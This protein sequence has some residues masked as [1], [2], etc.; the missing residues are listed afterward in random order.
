VSANRS[1]TRNVAVV[2]GA[3]RGVGKGIAEELGAA[4]AVVYVTGRSVRGEA[5]TVALPGTVDETADRVTRAG[6]TGVALHCDH[7]D[8]S[9]VEAVF[10]RVG[11][12]RGR[13]DLLVNNV[14]GGYEG[15]HEGRYEEFTK[16][17]WEQPVT[18]WDAMFSAGVRAHYVASALAA[19]MMV[20]QGRGLIVNV[21]SF[22]GAGREP[23]VALGVA[24]G[25]TDRL[26]ASTAGQ[27]RG[28]GVAVVSLYPGLVRTEGILKWADQIDLSNSESPRFVGGAVAAL[29]SDPNV[30][31]RTGQVLVA[32]ELA[33]EYGFT[34]V[35]GEQP[36]SLRSEFEVVA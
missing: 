35:D 28:H 34:D 25:A 21:S 12:E 27:L 1:L 18:L 13:L 15:L 36:R 5:A 31:D 29:A 17:F 33:E 14:W 23:N 8:D 32:A 22:A 11:A 16:P 3:S 24:K 26:T 7:R 2:T 19:R 6:G 9:Q 30:L 10:R 4:G 20:A